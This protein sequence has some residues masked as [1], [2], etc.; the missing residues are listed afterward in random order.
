ML[1]KTYRRLAGYGNHRIQLLTSNGDHVLGWGGMGIGD[2]RLYRPLGGSADQYV[3]VCFADQ[4]KLRI[5]AFG[6]L[7]SSARMTT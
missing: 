6:C 3:R 5:R 2:A 7:P 4:E 1:S